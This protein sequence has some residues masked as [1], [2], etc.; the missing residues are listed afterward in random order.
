MHRILVDSDVI[1]GLFMAREPHH[2]VAL[3]FFSYLDL[4]NSTVLGHVS[5]LAIA[6]AAYILTKTQSQSYAIKKIRVLRQILN[7]VSLAS[8]A[9]DAAI[10]TPGKDFEDTL[11]YQCAVANKLSTIVTRNVKD[12][13]RDTL[14][15]VTPQEFLAMDFMDK[16]T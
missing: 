2:S 11:Q 16:S 14:T 1:P 4:N 10:A 12:Y 13:P 9:V 15:I 7:I 8:S 5:P 3:R 6:N